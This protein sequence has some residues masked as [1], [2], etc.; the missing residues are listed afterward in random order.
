MM[1]YAPFTS[2]LGNKHG[3]A[4]WT[5]YRLALYHPGK[6]V[7]AGDDDSV[8]VDYDC[9]PFINRILVAG[10]FCGREISYDCLSSLGYN[11]TDSSEKNCIRPIVLGD[12]LWIIVLYAADQRSTA[13][14]ASSAGPAYGY[15]G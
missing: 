1:R 15:R 11:G 10:S 6:R 8:I 12:G 5:R 13:A 3:E 14:F 2:A 4:R 9:A 7:K